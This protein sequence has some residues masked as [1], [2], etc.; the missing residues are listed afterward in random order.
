MQYIR[1][2]YGWRHFYALYSNYSIKL[3]SSRCLQLSIFFS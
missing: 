3:T 2:R 1:S